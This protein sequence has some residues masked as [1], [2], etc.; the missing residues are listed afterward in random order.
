MRV[1]AAHTDLLPEALEAAGVMQI[2]EGAMGSMGEATPNSADMMRMM[3]S[4]DLQKVCRLLHRR[5][6]GCGQSPGQRKLHGANK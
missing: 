4:V 3:G 1:T 2:V 5:T 6:A